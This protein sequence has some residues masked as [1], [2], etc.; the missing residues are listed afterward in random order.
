MLYVSDLD[1]TLIN[2]KYHISRYSVVTVNKLIDQGL[3]FTYATARSY[4]SA[5]RLTNGLHLSWPV[6]VY[7]GAM[8]V[9]AQDGRIIDFLGFTKKQARLIESVLK[10]HQ[11]NPLVYTIV[12]NQEKVLW[13]FQKQND[14]IQR[15]VQ[16][17][18]GDVRF[19]PQKTA[20]SIF[21]GDIFYYT[22]IDCQESLIAVYQHLKQLLD[23]NCS[24]KKEFYSDEYF[25]KSCQKRRPKPGPCNDLAPSNLSRGWF[26]LAMKSMIWK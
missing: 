8:I 25:W 7:N 4:H 14:Y 11:I 17:H 26:V 20:E 23:C 10:T 12:N 9:S 2:S 21:Q 6:I 22:A 5:A 18:N 24:L 3:N 19:E 15:Y 16:A 1:G 13:H